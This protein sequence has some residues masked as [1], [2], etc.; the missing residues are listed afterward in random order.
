MARSPVGKPSGPCT[1]QPALS[2]RDQSRPSLAPREVLRLPTVPA[3]HLAPSYLP[4]PG[5][6]SGWETLLDVPAYLLSEAPVCPAAL[7]QMWDAEASQSLGPR[8]AGGAG[9]G[10]R[11]LVQAFSPLHRARP[12]TLTLP[13]RPHLR[14]VDFQLQ[15][16]GEQSGFTWRPWAVPQPRGQASVPPSPTQPHPAPCSRI[17]ACKAGSRMK[18]SGSRCR[19]LAGQRA[20]LGWG[21]CSP[22]GLPE[23]KE[24][25]LAC[26]PYWATSKFCLVA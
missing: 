6:L 24:R 22:P 18:G 3:G 17:Q 1:G 10:A 20:V 16:Q 4:A 23:Q 5:V 13:P 8:K 12:P 2:P 9:L 25:L 21:L 7:R 11:A 15:K 26:P 14:T 19:A